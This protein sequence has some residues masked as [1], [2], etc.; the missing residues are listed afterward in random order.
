MAQIFKPSLGLL[1]IL[2]ALVSWQIPARLVRGE[3]LSLRTRE[4][5]QAARGMGGGRRG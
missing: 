3:T 5:V 4:Y 2:L 1:I